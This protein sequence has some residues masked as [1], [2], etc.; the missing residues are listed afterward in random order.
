[1]TAPNQIISY[2][3]EK[4]TQKYKC[5]TSYIIVKFLLILQYFVLGK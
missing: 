1:M 5:F 2:S 4:A 3:Y